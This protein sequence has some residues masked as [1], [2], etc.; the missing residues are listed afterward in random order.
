MNNLFKFLVLAIILNVPSVFAQNIDVNPGA[1]SYPTLKDAFDAINAGTHTG[2]ITIDVVGN[3]VETATA[4]LNASGSGSANYTSVVIKPVGGARS[5]QGNITG[6]VIRLAGADNV[7]I[8]G[9]I[10]LSN[11]R[12][13]FIMNTGNASSSAAVWLS[14]GAGAATDSAGAQNNLIRNCIISTGVSVSSSANISFCIISSG[15]TILSTN[16][17]RNNNNNTI[18][19][20]ILY[21]ARYGVSICGGGA[22]SLNQNNRIDSNIVG[23]EAF[24]G[25]AIGKTG[26]LVQFQNDCSIQYNTV[27]YIGGP[28]TNTTGGADRVGIGV[29]QESWSVGFNTTT[30]GTNHTVNGN[31]I[32]SV[33]EGRTFSAAGI[34]CATTASGPPTGNKITNN[35]I[36]DII[37]NGTTPDL[38]V[39]IGHCGNR[40][41]LIAY[42]SI[43][44]VGDLD[45][46][47][48]IVGITSR[49]AVGIEVG[50]TGG[51]TALTIM[52]NSVYVDCTADT[53]TLPTSYAIIMPNNYGW[54]T[55]AGNYN[56]Y[57]IAANP[58]GRI[59]A[60]RTGTTYP[61]T[62]TFATLAAWQGA[63]TPAQDAN[64]I[65]ADPLYSLPPTTYLL[66]P[67]F[68]SPLKLNATPLASVTRDILKESRSPFTP[69]IGAYEYDS[70]T[71]P[72]ELVSFSSSVQGRDARLDWSTASELNNSGFDIERSES[73]NL[74]WSKV[75]FVTGNGTTNEMQA[76]S[77]TDRNLA[78]GSYL[79]R[80]KQI[81]FNGNYEYFN[82]TGEVLIG[83][84]GSFSLSQN[85]PNPFNP[86]T[87]INFD[88]PHDGNVS[89]TLF[90][91]SGREVAKLVNEFRQAGYHT[92]SFNASALSS[93]AYFYRMDAGNF[94]DTKKM[95]LIK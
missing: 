63:F 7:T 92:V 76:Y 68:A 52:N 21:R 8:D 90:D 22:T 36:Y 12:N 73:G 27:Q 89:I 72:V 35:V 85:F 50:S 65:S 48:G 54:G 71:L 25:G 40:G 42:N 9:R 47:G 80:L 10:G 30:T 16:Q 34:V 43:Y 28:S 82:L 55:G 46:P 20:N 74:Q 32:R 81:D 88:L 59:G 15:A 29:G 3:T 18:L 77:Y 95:L 83:V 66:M 93:G 61:Y 44:M 78:T 14:H 19:N 69:T 5:I 51:D 11:F 64:S 24:D 2:A 13:L 6:A 17:G 41:D 38:A 62:A 33:R 70:I 86:S 49:P 91:M 45:P 53:M 1:G 58:L 79:Y 23:S 94:A 31:I 67:Q 26:I 87:T 57:Y 56:N 4:V 84:P 39:G 75:G 37:A 60:L